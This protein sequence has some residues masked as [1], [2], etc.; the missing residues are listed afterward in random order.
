MDDMA[1]ATVPNMVCPECAKAMRLVG[2][3]R[4]TNNPKAHLVTF[5]CGA[6]HLTVF[7]V[8]G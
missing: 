7:T 3:E 6:G 1:P 2:I 4:D 8:P 5:E